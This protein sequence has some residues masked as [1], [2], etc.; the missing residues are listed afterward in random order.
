M[1]PGLPYPI[2]SRYVWKLTANMIKCKQKRSKY[3]RNDQRKIL[4]RFLCACES[5]T[6][7]V[8]QPDELTF[9]CA[10][11]LP[12]R[13]PDSQWSK[14]GRRHEFSTG[15]TDSDWGDRFR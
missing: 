2:T 9:H 13:A 5:Y 12:W 1:C 3:V 8:Q 7:Y 10:A 11:L 14:Q 15:G 4:K 6:T